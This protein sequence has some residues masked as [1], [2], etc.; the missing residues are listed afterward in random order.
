[1]ARKN[2]S[3]ASGHPELRHDSEQLRLL[4]RQILQIANSGM[5]RTYFLRKV[6][7]IMAEFFRAEEIVILLRVFDDPNRSE[8]V[9]YN[10][11]AFRYNFFPKPNNAAGQNAS[12]VRW[13]EYWKRILS[14]NTDASRSYVTPDGSIW[15]RDVRSAGTGKG[16]LPQLDMPGYDEA[17]EY[18]SMLLTPFI[19]DNDRIGLMEMKSRNPEFLSDFEIGS[20]E[21]FIQTFGMTLLNQHTQAAL[22]ERV[23]ELSCLYRMSRIADKPYVS[24]EDLIY[25]I[26][27]LIPPAWQ[28][29]EITRTRVILDGIDYSLPGFKSDAFRLSSEIV[30]DQAPRGRIEVIYT[31]ERPELD[32]GP[33]LKE[34]RK[35]LD[36]VANELALILKRKE[37]EDDKLKLVNQLHHAD[38]L[39]TVGELAAGVAH[40][41]N[42]PLGSILGF[43]QLA[44]KY[45]GI[46]EQVIKDLDKIVRASLHTREIVKKLMVFSRQV[47]AE[48]RKIN[49]NQIIE[50]SL[51]FFKSR[52]IKEGIQLDLL[53]DPD[54]P[55]IKA[56]PVQVNQVLVNIVVNAMQAMPDGGK[57]SIKTSRS[58]KKILLAIR[59]TG[60][61]MSP[62][63]LQQI[64]DPFFTT[65][66]TDR[67]LGLGLAVVDGIVKSMNGRIDVN[68]EPGKGSEFKITLPAAAVPKKKASE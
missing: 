12:A 45:P 63:V 49:L 10:R 17:G 53:L 22:Q 28:Y 8:L 58:G 66:G 65:K 31:E 59:D 43:A 13:D 19:R 5:T 36:A 44:G 15:I 6:M 39:A 37:S 3:S 57:L 20:I 61:G 18:R 48:K 50:E 60:Q 27:D 34:E 11:D 32:E 7:K 52:C 46:P 2:P 56:D 1:M 51:Y 54:I 25:S 26:M 16:I 24:P 30:T 62:D 33:F 23:K 64:F 42:E 38:R 67:G 29:P 35:L 14:G 47:S 41:I 55:E 68:S 9:Q 21:T 40:E 4:S